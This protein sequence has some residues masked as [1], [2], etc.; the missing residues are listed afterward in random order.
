MLNMQLSQNHTEIKTFTGGPFG[1]LLGEA[2]WGRGQGTAGEKVFETGYKAPFPETTVGLLFYL[3]TLNWNLQDRQSSRKGAWSQVYKYTS[4]QHPDV[5]LLLCSLR[6][7]ENKAGFSSFLV[8]CVFQWGSYN[9]LA[10]HCKR[11]PT[12]LHSYYLTFLGPPSLPSNELPRLSFHNIL[13]VPS[14][15]VYRITRALLNILTF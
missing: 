2:I 10:I 14:G 6:Q 12:T 8:P 7:V 4:P 9:F 13:G 1:S 3:S 5:A 11:N 15:P